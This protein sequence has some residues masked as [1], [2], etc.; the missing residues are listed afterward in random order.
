M[1][2]D[3]LMAMYMDPRQ[4]PGAGAGGAP[5]YASTGEGGGSY[6]AGYEPVPEGQ[7]D[8]YFNI[9]AQGN[10]T[11]DPGA[12]NVF[13]DSNTGQFRVSQ[14]RM[15]TG[16]IQRYLVD[17]N[18]TQDLGFE[19]A[20]WLDNPDNFRKLGLGLVGGLATGGLGLE[21][22]AGGA[23][24]GGGGAAAGS[25][26]ATGSAAGAGGGL[27]GA[28]FGAGLESMPTFLGTGTGALG[29]A[30][31]SIVGAGGID[32]ASSLGGGGF[33]A[34]AGGLGG[35][36]GAFGADPSLA[37]TLGGA[38]PAG[39]GSWA[40]ILRQGGNAL[41]GGGGLGGLGALG[42]AGLGALAG[43][44][45]NGDITSSQNTSGTSN[46]SGSNSQSLAPWLQ[47]YAQDY[48]GRAQ[49]LANAPTTN[50]SLD[51]AGGLLSNYATQGDSLVNQARAQQAN[52]IGGGLLGGNPYLDQVAGNIGRRMGDAYATG[53]RAGVFSGYNNDGN[54]VQAKSGFGQ[55]LGM[56]DRNYADAL[57]STMSNLYMGNYNTER[58]AQDAASRGSLGFGTFGV[59]NATNLAG[60]GA[61]QF[62]RPFMAN[63]AYGNAINPAFGSTSNSNATGTTNNTQTQNVTA[64][65]SWMAGLGGAA[66]GAGLYRNIF[67]GR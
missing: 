50:A 16:G 10:Y 21:M 7:R 49:Q 13:Y 61:D 28:T 11:K 56:Q 36:M 14:G 20:S 4:L 60:F 48:V 64:P 67:G 23:L 17:Q 33:A 43:V 3:Q 15:D 37:S 38:A 58:A 62:Q 65:N 63:Q 25:A 12:Q 45:G 26:G 18:G 66:A 8:P 27:G 55:A 30:G 31:A 51:T 41:T 54:S 22:M 40:D 9:D 19:G 1:T 52:V 5:I 47:G 6:I 59:N 44:A 42:A 34:G 2:Y 39:G 32:A 46:T 53:T 29:P 57:G 24:S 35:A